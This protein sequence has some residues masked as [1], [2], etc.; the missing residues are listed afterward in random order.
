M[1]NRTANLRFKAQANAY[2]QIYILFDHLYRP[3][4]NVGHSQSGARPVGDAR[5]PRFTQLLPRH[6]GECTSGCVGGAYGVAYMEWHLC[7]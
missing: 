2:M 4:D 3:R 1:P 7:K 5:A 6:S